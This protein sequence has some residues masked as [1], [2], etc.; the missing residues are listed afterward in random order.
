MGLFNDWFKPK[1]EQPLAAEAMPAEPEAK[2]ENEE[3]INAGWWAS[4]IAEQLG[5]EEKRVE[6]MLEL[7]DADERMGVDE[8]LT[9]SEVQRRLTGKIDEGKLE[10]CL[11]TIKK[12]DLEQTQQAA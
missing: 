11:E 3:K 12:K 7:K 8:K 1:I 5:E 4:E 9:A 10:Q 2:N 6:E